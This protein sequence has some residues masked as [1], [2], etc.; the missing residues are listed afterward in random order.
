ME[1]IA[2]AIDLLRGF[3]FT[4]EDFVVRLSDRAFWT[5]FLARAERA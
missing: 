2:L 5:D 1:L 3:G 4:A